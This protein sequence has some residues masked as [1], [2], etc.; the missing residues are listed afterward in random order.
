[1]DYKVVRKAK[2]E[3]AGFD[4]LYQN[5][6]RK[7][8]IGGKSKR[9]IESYTL[10]LAQISL[11]LKKNALAL[12]QTELEEY[13]YYLKT[14]NYGISTFKFAVYALRSLFKTFGKEEL[15][16]KLPSIK[17]TN[18][19]PVVLSVSECK[20]LIKTPLKLRDRFLLAFFYSSGL[21]LA[22]VSDLKIVDVDKDRMQIHVHQGKGNKDRIVPL[23]QFIA[24]S[25]DKYYK[26]CA[27]K[28]YFF[29]STEPGRQFSKRGIQRVVR[30]A[31]KASGIRKPVSAHTLRH[32]YATHLLENGVDLLTIKEVLGHELIATTMIYLH[33]AK[34]SASKFINPLDVLY[35]VQQ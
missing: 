2:Q 26:V 29:N 6:V 14:E 31:V 25:L 15:K 34:P 16:T 33:I 28:D 3:V 7:L 12:N 8:T 32:T 21:R 30:A 27:P 22:E 4:T 1:M 19:L 17:H 24:K 9:T 5:Y 10:S 13:L 20:Q 35:K 18:K 11:F 23:S